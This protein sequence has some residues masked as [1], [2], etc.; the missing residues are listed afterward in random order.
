MA[1]EFSNFLD[2]TR[3]APLREKVDG[4]SDIIEKMMM[5]I[6]SIPDNVDRLFA[7]IND[8]ITNIDKKINDLDG[9]IANL[10]VAPAAPLAANS[11]APIASPGVPPPPPGAPPRPGAPPT[12]PRPANPVSLRSSIMGELKELFK[13]RRA[14]EN[15]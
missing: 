1:E 8:K 13:K 10:K 11:S 12:P 15:D 6:M 5:L 7:N 3:E 9:K 2:Q 14:W 4:L